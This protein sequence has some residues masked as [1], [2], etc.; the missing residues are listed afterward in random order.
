MQINTQSVDNFVVHYSKIKYL[1]NTFEGCIVFGQKQLKFDIEFTRNFL[2]KIFLKTI[3]VNLKSKAKPKIFST[4]RR[5]AM[6]F[7]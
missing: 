1:R 7:R 2:R 6:Y 3:W 4:Q 5:I